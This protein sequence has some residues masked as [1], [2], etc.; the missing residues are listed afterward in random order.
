MSPAQSQDLLS[1]PESRWGNTASKRWVSL[2]TG[3]R[4]YEAPCRGL[5]IY[6]V[7]V[8]LRA[9]LTGYAGCFET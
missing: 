4:D 6:N 2:C 9:L 5:T 3:L 7:V 1:Y 8:V